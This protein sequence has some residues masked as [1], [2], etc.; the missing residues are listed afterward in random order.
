MGL[1][2]ASQG[3][4]KS[5]LGMEIDLELRL[6]NKREVKKRINQAVESLV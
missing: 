5:S 3:R 2:H 1:P 6:L 4:L